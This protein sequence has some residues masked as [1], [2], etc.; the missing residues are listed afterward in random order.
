MILDGGGRTRK[1]HFTPPPNLSICRN[2]GG[3]IRSA[4][5]RLNS[6]RRPVA[7]V[8]VL[9]VGSVATSQTSDYEVRRFDDGPG[10]LVFD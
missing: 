2:R 4:I 10:W 1:R 8:A 6:F 7:A 9:S 3:E 5:V